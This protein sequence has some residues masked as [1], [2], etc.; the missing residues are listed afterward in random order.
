[1]NSLFGDTLRT[2]AIEGKD[3]KYNNIILSDYL[4]KEIKK[5]SEYIIRK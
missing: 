3:A 1:M 2:I 5:I 4:L